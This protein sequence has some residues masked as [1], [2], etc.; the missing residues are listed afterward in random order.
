[1]GYI[2]LRTA[3]G[4]VKNMDKRTL[5]D[6]LIGDGRPLLLFTGLILLLSGLF[7]IVQSA[8]GHFL[9]HDVTYLGLDAQQLSV[10]NQGTITKFMFHDRVSF[11]GS[12]VAVGLLYMWLAEFPLKKGE[13]WAW[14]LFVFSGVIGF[15]SF[16]TYMGYGYLDTWHGVA[17]ALL[18]PFFITGVIQSYN[19]ILKGKSSIT[20]V[21][22]AGEKIELRS[23]YGIGKLL[24]FFSSLGIFLAGA[25]IM[26]VGM[27]SV[28]VPQDLEYMDITVCGIEKINKNLKPLIAHDRAA[29]G[30]GLA[31][32]GLLLFFIIRRS[33]PLVSLWQI[34]ALSIGVGFA[35][36]VGVHF[37]IQY[38]NVIH[39]LPAYMGFGTSF[40][41]L[42][43]T[44]KKMTGK[45]EPSDKAVSQ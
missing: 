2:Y 31:T 38:T 23:A 3:A 21:F 25:T 22:R 17:T 1:M 44:Y 19:K 18:L 24:L 42:L 15:G 14:Y 13:S 12:I 27:T 28:F 37:F 9:P 5:L 26:V 34:V 6:A 39:L 40:L 35:T 10:Y 4:H 7:V 8:T 45:H 11:G 20:E 29:F 32:I 33:E 16:L 36:A 43:L 41:G 30:G